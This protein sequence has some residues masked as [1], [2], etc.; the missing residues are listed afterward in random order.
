MSLTLVRPQRFEV[1]PWQEDD[2]NYLAPLDYS[3]NWSS[4]GVYKTSTGLWLADR[5]TEAPANVLIVSTKSGK[6]VYYDAIPRC[7]LDWTAFTVGTRKAD[8]V[9]LPTSQLIG[10]DLDDFVHNL[11]FRTTNDKVAVLAHYNC[12]TNSSPMREILE[13]I[14]WDFTLLDEAHR[15]KN[16][17]AQW[18][19][20]LKKLKS[21]Y[22]H[23]MTGTGFVNDPSEIWSLFNFLAP[24][25]W[26]SY[27]A[28]RRTMCLEEQWSGFNRVIGLKPEAVEIF[29]RQRRELGPRR[30][31][32]EVHAH[33]KEPIYTNIEVDLNPTQRRM[34]NEILRELRM[35]DQNDVAISSPNI[36]SQLSRLRQISVATPEFVEDYYDEKEERRVQVVKL[37]EPSSKLDAVMELLEGLEWDE[38]NRQQ[39]VIFSNFRD[40]LELLKVR[41]NKAKIP[42][43]HMEEKDSEQVRF[44]KWRELFPTKQHQVFLST[45]DLGGESITLSCAQYCIFLDRS[46]SPAKNAQAVSR[47]W[48]PGQEGVVEV[49]YINARKTIDNRIFKLNE[50]KRGWFNAI[51]DE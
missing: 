18:T 30:T 8:L 47:L 29:R 11:K 24:H 48:R 50:L 13:G 46:W 21:V 43:I 38:E 41:L 12:F 17:K 23:V 28:F 1:Q 31:M 4:M 3:A 32:Q 16:R 40:P 7:G 44:H 39:V 45:I 22:R 51:F 5:K 20:N 36:L 49:I 34:Y 42:F 37:V 2:L 14:E 9:A 33:I 19:K 25:V 6:S 10:I 26:R 35:L 27:W 15:I